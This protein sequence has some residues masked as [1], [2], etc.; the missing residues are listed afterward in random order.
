MRSLVPLAFLLLASDALA[1]EL[2]LDP[3]TLV[4]PAATHQNLTFYPLI[5]RSDGPPA[6]YLVLDEGLAGGQV[7]VVEKGGGA[8]VNRLSLENRSQKPLFVMSG[9]VVIGGKQDRIIGKDAVIGPNETV[10][11]P[12]FCVEHGRWTEGQAGKSFRSAGS[13]ADTK[14]RKKA[15]FKDS[16]SEVWQEV[17]SKNQARGIANATG[18]YR[19]VATGDGGVKK[20]VEPYA[21]ALDPA[22]AGPRTVGMVVALNGKVVGVEQFGSPALFAKV[23]GKLARSYYV[24]AVDEPVAAGARQPTVADMKEFVGKTAGG[25]ESVVAQHRTARTTRKEANGVVGAE[26]VDEKAPAKPVY[27]TVHTAE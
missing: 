22:L 9:E 24:D 1:E 18:T 7:R 27:K 20:A 25:K 5:A 17:A 6:D 3:D 12:V 2:A 16:Q 10:D 11:V 15:A 13:M 21:R 4:G 26:V 23:R 19:Q 14:V 8:E